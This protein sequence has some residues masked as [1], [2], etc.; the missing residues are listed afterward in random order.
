MIELNKKHCDFILRMVRTDG[1]ANVSS[2]ATMVSQSHLT[3]DPAVWKNELSPTVFDWCFMMLKTILLIGG[4]VLGLDWMSWVATLEPTIS[5][6]YLYFVPLVPV[7]LYGIFLMHTAVSN[8]F[9]NGIL[10]MGRNFG[11]GLAVAI[12]KPL[13][14]NCFRSHVGLV[15]IAIE[16]G[17]FTSVHRDVSCVK[18]SRTTYFLAVWTY[19]YSTTTAPHYFSFD[20]FLTFGHSK[21]LWTLESTDSRE[22]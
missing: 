2:P 20:R 21:P 19:W 11:L 3:F 18:S 16:H 9:A 17:V 7:L 15:S 10:L 12:P 22:N 4:N 6:K 13:I 14:A 8:A 1:K 5:T